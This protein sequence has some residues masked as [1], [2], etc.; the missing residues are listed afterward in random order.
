MDFEQESI[1][2]I[3]D[4]DKI[5]L[6]NS[7]ISSEHLLALSTALVTFGQ[8]EDLFFPKNLPE[9]AIA[10]GI[11]IMTMQILINQK[12]EFHK[13]QIL[14]ASCIDLVKYYSA[15]FISAKYQGMISKKRG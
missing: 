1:C 5:V 4:V 15:F 8:K 13:P 3:K 12:Q 10:N 14:Y 7:K 2:R 11:A 6:T 9:L